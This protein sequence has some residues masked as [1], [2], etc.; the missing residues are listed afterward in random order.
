MAHG[1]NNCA[2]CVGRSDVELIFIFFRVAKVK[3]TFRTRTRRTCRS[4]LSSWVFAIVYMSCF[5]PRVA[6]VYRC[7]IQCAYHFF[8]GSNDDSMVYNPEALVVF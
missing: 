6:P 1:R 2:S 3:S 4:C 8:F 5:D 7:C